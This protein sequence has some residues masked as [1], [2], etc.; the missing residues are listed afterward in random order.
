L[1][2]GRRVS[3]RDKHIAELPLGALNALLAPEGYMIHAA[4]VRDARRAVACADVHGRV[5]HYG[6]FELRAITGR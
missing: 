1:P 3:L 2:E 4:K 5:E 6:V